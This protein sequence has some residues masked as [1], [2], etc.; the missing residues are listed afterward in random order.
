MP[1]LGPKIRGEPGTGMEKA[2][3]AEGPVLGRGLEVKKPH[4]KLHYPL[5]VEDNAECQQRRRLEMEQA[6][7]TGGFQARGDC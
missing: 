4:H 3:E 6:P 7:T 1:E 2:L 5:R